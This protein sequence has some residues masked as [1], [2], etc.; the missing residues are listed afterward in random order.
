MTTATQ[1]RVR[2]VQVD[3]GRWL[4]RLL[5]DVQTEI[6]LQPSASVIERIRSRL[7]E[8]MHDPVRAAA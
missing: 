5:A 3:N 2:L 1:E 6:A 7:V 8:E 4:S